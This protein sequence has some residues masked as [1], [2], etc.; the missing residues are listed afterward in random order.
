MKS[1]KRD[2]TKMIE[3]LTPL[4]FYMRKNGI[5]YHELISEEFDFSACSLQGVIYKLFYDGFESGVESLNK[6]KNK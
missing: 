4:G 6:E 2:Y 5:F 1:T 3:L